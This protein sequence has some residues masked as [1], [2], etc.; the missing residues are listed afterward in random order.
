M[1][2]RQLHGPA[3][4]A[5]REAKGIPG[6]VFCIRAGMSHGYLVHIEKG[7]RRP[8]WEKVEAIARALEVPIEAITYEV[9]GERAA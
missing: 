4:R 1:A 6:S 9:A 7:E 3:V 5:I 2:Q 8:T